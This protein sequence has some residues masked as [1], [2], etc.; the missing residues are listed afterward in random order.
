MAAQRIHVHRSLLDHQVPRLVKHQDGLLSGALDW[1][2][3]HLRPRHRLADRLR[4]GRVVLAALDVGLG[5]GRRHQDHVV[6][7]RLQFPRPIMRRPASFHANGARRHA[8]EKLTEFRSREFPTNRDPAF[9]LDRM[10]LKKV[11]RQ[12][13]ANSDKG[14]HGRSP[15]W[16]RSGDHVLALD[17]VRVRPS[18]PSSPHA[19]GGEQHLDQVVKPLSVEAG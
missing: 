16:W 13:Y 3:T 14:S 10:N 2:E 6:S 18:T 8:F 4:V 12:I 15:R 1:N 19:I 17:A 9:P 7:H 5:V 11:L